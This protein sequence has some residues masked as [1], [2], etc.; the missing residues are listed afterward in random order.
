[1]R[2]CKF[3]HITHKSPVVFVVALKCRLQ[4]SETSCACWALTIVPSVLRRTIVVNVAVATQV[5]RLSREISRLQQKRCRARQAER[6]ADLS[7]F[8]KWVVLAVF[9]LSGCASSV[10]ASYIA[11][12]RTTRRLPERGEDE[13]AGIV[14]DLYLRTPVEKLVSLEHAETS[15]HR[16]AREAAGRYL[17]GRSTVQWI[18]VQ[19]RQGTAPSSTSMAAEYVRRCEQYGSDQ[20]AASFSRV[21]CNAAA[22]HNNGR[23]LRSW[24]TRFRKEWGLYF[25]A[26][27]PRAAVVVEDLREKASW[28]QQSSVATCGAACHV[29]FGS[30]SGCRIWC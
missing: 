7:A 16:R 20:I 11:H 22:S 1:M 6:D 19:N 26:L 13:L 25:G 3:T 9:I 15:M 21:L 23:A 12:V 29:R 17:A 4:L 5:R 27:K 2:G 10:A 28:L 24:S 14:E 30:I 18:G 8:Q